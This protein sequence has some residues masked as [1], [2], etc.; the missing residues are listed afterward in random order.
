MNTKVLYHFFNQILNVSSVFFYYLPCGSSTVL[1]D[2][3]AS[4]FFG[5]VT[6]VCFRKINYYFTVF[7]NIR[8]FLQ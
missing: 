5:C 8:K 1:N 3:L 6:S 2:W 4:A 7:L